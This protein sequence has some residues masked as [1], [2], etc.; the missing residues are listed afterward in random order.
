MLRKQAN[1]LLY[2]NYRTSTTYL[3]KTHS[4]SGSRHCW[5]KSLGC[6]RRTVRLLV[7]TRRKQED[8]TNTSECRDRRSLKRGYQARFITR[9][10]VIKRRLLYRTWVGGM[11]PRQTV[12][13]NRGLELLIA[14][15]CDGQH[16]C[17][18]FRGGRRRDGCRGRRRR[19]VCCDGPADD[20]KKVTNEKH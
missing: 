15:S 13:V 3:R 8:P 12:N 10:V 6:R 18:G 2:S 20:G 11:S 4:C 1:C 5:P 17:D 19:R 7:S 14:T 16:T 9:T